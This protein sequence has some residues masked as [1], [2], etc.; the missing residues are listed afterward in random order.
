MQNTHRHNLDMGM[1]DKD[2]HNQGFR[3]HSRN[4]YAPSFYPVDIL[5]V[6]SIV[7]DKV[8]NFVWGLAEFSKF[9]T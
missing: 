4:S 9:M 8:A 1:A 6:D 7:Y 3:S 5:L 2:N